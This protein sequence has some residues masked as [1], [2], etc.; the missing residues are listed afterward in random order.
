MA[1]C[2]PSAWDA[3]AGGSPSSRP[4]CLKGVE[5]QLGLDQSLVFKNQDT[6][7]SSK[8]MMI[9][10]FILMPGLPSPGCNLCSPG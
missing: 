9:Y 5:G 7:N 2:N 6:D 8:W 10:S 4:T 3:E 1:S